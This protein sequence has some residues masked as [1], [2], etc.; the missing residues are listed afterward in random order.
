MFELQYLFGDERDFI[1][2]RTNGRKDPVSLYH[3]ALSPSRV[4]ALFVESVQA[5]NRLCRQ[6]RFYNVIT[7]NCPTSLRAQTPVTKRDP[8]DIQMLLNGRVGRTAGR[9]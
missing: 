4:A 8:F 1:R 7:A 3:A 2:S 9:T 5:H 6:P